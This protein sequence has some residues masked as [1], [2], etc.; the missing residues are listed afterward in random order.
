MPKNNIIKMTYAELKY[1]IENMLTANSQDQL[2]EAYLTANTK[3]VDLFNAVS[4]DLNESK[5]YK[6]EPV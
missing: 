6:S 3:L 4:L 2:E 5:A 1:N